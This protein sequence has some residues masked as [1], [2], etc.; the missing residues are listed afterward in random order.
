MSNNKQ[1]EETNYEEFKKAWGALASFLTDYEHLKGLHGLTQKTIAEKAQ[2]SQSAIS[3][4]QSM[5]GGGPTYNDLQRLSNAVGGDL[6]ITPLADVTI[7]LP[8]DLQDKARQIA[9]DRGVSVQEFLKDLIRTS[10]DSSTGKTSTYTSNICFPS[11][12]TQ[13][14]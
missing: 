9:S 7:T 14:K 6:F 11:F 10:M 13:H 5:K 3:R 12:N 8:Y 2:T 1:Q 4:M